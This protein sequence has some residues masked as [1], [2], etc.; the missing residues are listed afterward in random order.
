[1]GFLWILDAKP[2]NHDLILRK[3]CYLETN[4]LV[5]LMEHI[6]NI[7]VKRVLLDKFNLHCIQLGT[8]KMESVHGKKCSNIWRINLWIQIC[9]LWLWPWLVY[10]LYYF[11]CYSAFPGTRWTSQT[12]Y[13]SALEIWGWYNITNIKVFCTKC[14]GAQK[15]SEYR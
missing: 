14:S 8:I 9:F 2:L 7:I 5:F 10:S 11:R 12:N 13:I 15:V 3:D 6:D 1:M 4:I